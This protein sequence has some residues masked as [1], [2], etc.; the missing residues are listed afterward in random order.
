[1]INVITC[2]ALYLS[3]RYKRKKAI[4]AQKKAAPIY[5]YLSA[6]NQAIVIGLKAKSIESGS[7]INNPEIFLFFL[8]KKIIK[9]TNTID[10][11]AITIKASGQNNS[12]S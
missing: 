7:K 11:A 1:M 5:K 6:I 12:P 2:E 8:K 9:T 4:S 3:S 10:T